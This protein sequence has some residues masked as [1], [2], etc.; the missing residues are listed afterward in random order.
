[1]HRPSTALSYADTPRYL[2]ERR[3]STVCT[4]P[5]TMTGF[6]VLMND[7]PKKAAPTLGMTAPELRKLVTR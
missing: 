1:M 6:L 5:M 7:E 2:H 3:L 4:S